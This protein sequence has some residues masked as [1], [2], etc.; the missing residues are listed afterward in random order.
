MT[1]ASRW[2]F[3]WLAALAAACIAG[4]ALHAPLPDSDAVCL[5]LGAL[6]GFWIIGPVIW[7][8]IAGTDSVEFC[9]YC[10]CKTWH[11]GRVCEWSEGHPPNGSITGA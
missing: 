1:F 7:V 6:A 3:G 2:A 5:A 8:M 9:P 11:S 10:R 4:I